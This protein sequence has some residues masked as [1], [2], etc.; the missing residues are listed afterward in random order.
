MLVVKQV[1]GADYRLVG[2]VGQRQMV[3]RPMEGAWR[4]QNQVVGLEPR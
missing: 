4:R 2:G 1:E 3:V